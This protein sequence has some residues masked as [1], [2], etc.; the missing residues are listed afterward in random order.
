MGGRIE[1]MDNYVIIRQWVAGWIISP[2][3]HGSVLKQKPKV[4]IDVNANALLEGKVTESISYEW[5]FRISQRKYQE[6]DEVPSV[7]IMDQL[8]SIGRVIYN[9]LEQGYGILKV[10]GD[11]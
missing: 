9:E 2:I 10:P 11:G 3:T 8:S 4:E 1:K 7:R 5:L 6:Q